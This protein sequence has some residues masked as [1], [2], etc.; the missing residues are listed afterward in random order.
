VVH[1]VPEHDVKVTVWRVCV[2]TK[3]VP[4]FFK[5]TVNSYHYWLILTPFF[6]ELTQEEKMYCYFM[7]SNAMQ[8]TQQISY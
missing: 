5:E 7:H 6:K 3:S 8:P 4:V 2:C 1:K